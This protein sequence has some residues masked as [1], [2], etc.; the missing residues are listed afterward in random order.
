M[1]VFVTFKNEEDSIKY[2]GAKMPQHYTFILSDV[3]WQPTVCSGG[4]R[5]R[6]GLILSKL[7]YMPS[8]SAK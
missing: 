1:V 5:L 4:I 7:L 2:M 8:L 6:F 3:Q